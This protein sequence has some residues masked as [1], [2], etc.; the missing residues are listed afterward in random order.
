MQ[1]EVIDLPHNLRT[2]GAQIIDTA[3]IFNTFI[4]QNNLIVHS[5]TWENITGG[6]EI[7]SNDKIKFKEERNCRNQSPILIPLPISLGLLSISLID[8]SLS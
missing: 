8:L 3:E 5:V 1:Y 7:V 6:M 2:E 4:A